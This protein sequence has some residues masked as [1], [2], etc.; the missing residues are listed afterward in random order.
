MRTISEGI[1]NVLVEINSS[2][3]P[4][5]DGSAKEFIDKIKKGDGQSGSVDN[6]DKII[7]LR[8]K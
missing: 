4:I 6:P 3:V 7:S 5:M 2:E 1:D 8:S